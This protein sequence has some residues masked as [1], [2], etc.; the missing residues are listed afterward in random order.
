VLYR[1][2]TNGSSFQVIHKFCSAGNCGSLRA[3][4]TALVAGTDG[5]LYGTILG[6]GST[7][8]SIFRV[9]PSTGAYKIILNFNF[10]TGEGVA[11]GLNVAPD[12]TFYAI[13]LGSLPALLLH[14]TPATRTLTT[15]TLNFPLF[16]GDLPSSPKTGLIFGPNGNLYGV[17]QIYAENGVGLFEVQPDGSNLQFF[18]FYT[19][20][21]SG[22][23]PDGLILASDGNF[24]TADYYGSD[25][26]G[27]I[28]SVSPTDGTLLQMFTPF[29]E[30]AAVGA[31]PEGI[32]QASDGTLWGTTYQYGN[33]SAGHFGDGT[34]FSLNVG[35]PPR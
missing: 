25:V 17:Y 6:E 15:A 27:D 13:A 20:A 9:T 21:V 10:S 29:S 5:N 24:W 4:A 19:T 30:T 22:G 32:I 3:S 33:A 12:G 26:F 2:N 7:Y 11:S 14:Y 18:P 28:V 34:V 31:Y 8:G 1:V 35:L 23:T 16:N